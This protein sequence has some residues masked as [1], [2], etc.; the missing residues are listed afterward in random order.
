MRRTPARSRTCSGLVLQHRASPARRH[1]A[2]AARAR[3]VV[4]RPCCAER[5]DRRRTVVPAAARQRQG[6]QGGDRRPARV[7]SDCSGLHEIMVDDCGSPTREPRRRRA[8]SLWT[9]HVSRLSGGAHAKHR[10]VPPCDARVGELAEHA[11]LVEL[12]AAGDADAAQ[13]LAHR[14]L[15][16]HDDLAI[17]S[18]WTIRSRPNAVPRDPALTAP[19]ARSSQ[20]GEHLRHQHH[21][22]HSSRRLRRGRNP[23]ASAA[24]GR[25]WRRRLPRRWGS[26]EGYVLTPDEARRLLDIGVEELQGRGA[27]AGDGL[28]AAYRDRDDRLR[29]GRR[30]AGVDA[31]QIYSLDQGHG[32]RPNRRKCRRISMTCCRPSSCRP[33]CRRINPWATRCR[34]TCCRLR[35]ALRAP[36]RHQLHASGPGLSR[37]HR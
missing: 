32:H 34:S 30:A 10:P 9:G 17:P 19:S 27:G 11:R 6:Q 22:F 33:C 4:R 35:R 2:D 31:T 36:D 3:P 14:H 25:R 37:R 21:P 5:T 1:G 16:S 20:A 8:R 23:P 7:R 15:T 28:R 26:G 29:E 12:I 24:H 18:R 13:R